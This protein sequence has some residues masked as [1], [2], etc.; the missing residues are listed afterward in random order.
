MKT[1]LSPDEA[2][3]VVLQHS[4]TLPQ[5]TVPHAAALG[6]TLASDVASPVELPPFDNSSV[7]GYALRADDTR[8]A[9]PQ[10]PSVLAVLGTSGAGDTGEY[11]IEACKSVR[12]MTGAPLPPGADAVVMREDTIEA[13][14]EV[15]VL[16]EARLGQAIRRR[17][18]DVR[19]GEI[20]MRRGA[21]VRAAEWGMLASLG[22]TQVSV[23][24][25][26]RVGVVVTGAELVDV[27]RVLLPGQ[28]HDSNS[29]TLRGLVEDCGAEVSSVRRVGDDAEELRATLQEMFLL[30]D[31]IVTSGGVSMGDFDPVRDVLPTLAHVHF[32]KIAVKP[33][34]PVM[35]ATRQ[36][37]ECSVPIWGLPGNPVSVM[38][39]FEQFVRPALLQ[40]QGRRRTERETLR[41]RVLEHFS[42]PPGRAE[43]VRVQVR[44]DKLAPAGETLWVAQTTGDQGSGRLSTMTASNALLVVPADVTHVAAGT[45]MDVQMTDWPEKE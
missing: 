40:M 19:T 18:S 44:P 34:K 24:R 21:R 23:F 32:W 7:D 22:C 3:R 31:A 36:Q 35:F 33:G 25:Q 2:R 5:E 11:S 1:L 15:Q 6:R 10:S 29:W 13:E 42:S 27:E 12:I 16:A 41:V 39:S 43:F 4:P 38:V 14:A 17:G 37:D 8:G 20:V 26:P 9:S 30:C 45:F 28:I